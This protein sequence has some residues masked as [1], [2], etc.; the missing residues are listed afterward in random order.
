MGDVRRLLMTADTIGGVFTYAVDLSR[1]LGA[2]GVEVVLATMGR[3]PSPEQRGQAAAV[4]SLTLVESSYK[5]EWMDEPWEDVARAGGW[6]LDLERRYAPDVVHL[7]GYVHA[8]LPFRAPCLVVGH[9]CVLS[10]WQA[11]KGEPAPCQY[12]VYRERV[13]AGLTHA[14]LV[15]APTSAM[16]GALSRHYGR[17]ARAV[18]VP[19]G[20]DASLFVPREKHASVAAAGRMWDEAKNLETLARAARSL[21]WPVT[22]A[23]EAEPPAHTNVRKSAQGKSLSLRGQL[24]RPA[25]AEL[26]GHS[27]IYAF[28]ARY[29]PFGLSV[30]EAAASGA[31]LVLSDIS[32]FREL[33]EGAAVFVPADDAAALAS[34]VESLIA[35]ATERERLSQHG[36]ARALRFGLER[37][38]RSYRELY[39]EVVAARRARTRRTEAQHAVGR[40]PRVIT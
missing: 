9:S 2:L 18:S 25:L 8:V 28:P 32:T 1:A 33:W 3:W 39:E 17:L 19:N 35:D 11:V 24:S 26:F 40:E 31:A 20:C 23:G 36:R 37:F 13:H 4:E 14:D 30:V 6:L 27:A 34:A 15:V 38:G 5:L 7:N 22:I 21:S 10:W 12:D 29:E 16:L